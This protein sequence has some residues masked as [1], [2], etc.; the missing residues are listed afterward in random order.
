LTKKAKQLIK[1]NNKPIGSCSTQQKQFDSS[2][3]GID[4]SLSSPSSYSSTVSNILLAGGAYSSNISESSNSNNM[5]SSLSCMLL[6]SSAAYSTMPTTTSS[7]DY[8]HSSENY[9]TSSNRTSSSSSSSSSSSAQSQSLVSPLDESGYLVPINLLNMAA[10]NSPFV[11]NNSSNKNF[12]FP[13]LKP[14]IND[15]N[16]HSD[17]MVNCCYLSTNIDAKCLQVLNSA[18][19]DKSKHYQECFYH[20]EK[21]V[22]KLNKIV[23]FFLSIRILNI[24]SKLNKLKSIFFF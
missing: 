18:D 11:V 7:S 23:K 12:N 3:S 8:S 17:E 6:A 22:I 5:P 9:S 13:Q 21:K 10:S 14:T 15:Q 4:I 24:F 1:T 20:M 16:G 2:D 19:N